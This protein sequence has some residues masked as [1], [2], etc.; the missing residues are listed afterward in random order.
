MP[1]VTI[2]GQPG[3]AAHDIGRL[4]A[5]R[6]GIDYIDQE[7]LVQAASTLG[8]SM[9][10]IVAIDERTSTFGER[11]ATML[12]RFLERSAAAGA[13]DPMLGTPGSLDLVLS[14]SYAEAA[15]DDSSEDLSDERYIG[16]LTSL[17]HDLAAHDN[18]VIIGRGSQAILKDRPG[19][20]HT[21]LVAPLADRIESLAQ[22]EGL[23]KEAATKREHD[24]QRARVAFHQKFFKIDVD[25]PALY[26][27]VLNTARLTPDDVAEMIAA[28]VARVA[29]KQPA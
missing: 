18:V 17:V 3:T 29:T 14:R 7:I 25:K 22:R 26:H 4:T 5:Q 24:G 11:V 2:S 20:L 6:L 1:V 13:S 28:A 23:S 27:V 8:V 15:A 19:V 12:R 21:L 16:V 10:S 9:E